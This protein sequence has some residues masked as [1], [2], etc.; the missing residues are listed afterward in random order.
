MPKKTKKPKGF[1]NWFTRQFNKSKLNLRMKL[2][3]LFVV[4][5]VLPL[6]I[7]AVI[8]WGQMSS[9]GSLL[10]EIAV[11]DSTVALNNSA[12]E[13]IE[14]MTTDTAADVAEFLY[15]R[16]DDIRYVASIVSALYSESG[17]SD[18]ENALATFVQN[19]FGGVTV[20]GEYILSEE[21]NKWVPTAVQDMSHTVGES[22]N[23]QN[24]DRLNGSGFHPVAASPLSSVEAP[25]YDEVTFIGL[26]GQEIVRISTTQMENSRKNA[27]ADWFTTGAL[28]DVSKRENTFCKAEVYWDAL[29]L[30]TNEAGAD[31]YVS[32][33]IGAYTPSNYIGTYTPENVDSASETRGYDIEY[34]PE[35]Q[36][37]AGE[38]N[39]NGVR[40]EG[41]VR[42]A[43]PVYVDGQKVGYVTLALDHDHI[44]EFVDHQTPMSE[45]YTELPSAAAGNY[46]FIWDYQCRSICHPRHNSIVGYDPETGLEAI[47]WISE[48]IYRNLL[49]KC[50]VTDA[51]YDAY[52]A[53]ERYALLYENWAALINSSIDGQ[54][55]YDLIIGQATFENQARTGATVPEGQP[56]PDH[57]VAA[58]L[59]KLG[60]V[61]L[62]GRYLNNAPQCTGWLDLTERGGSGSLYILWSGIYKPNTAAAIPYYTGQYAPSEAN[63][64]SRVGF[65]FV[66]IGAGIED[67]TAPAD[68]TEQRLNEASGENMR[69][70]TLRLVA[71]TVGL[72]TVVVLIALWTASF[73]TGNIRFV[74]AGIGRFRRGERHFRFDTEKKDEFGQ[75]ED[76]FDEMANSVVNSVN[77][78]LVITDLDYKI[79]YMNQYALDFDHVTLEEVIGKSYRDYGM[80]PAGSE[81]DPIH[82]LLEGTEA[83]VYPYNSEGGTVYLRGSAHYLTDEKGEKTGFIIITNDVSELSLKQI[84]LEQAVE[85]ANIA[86]KHKGEFLARMSH[87]IRTPMNAI[88]GLGDIMQRDLSI[89]EEEEA[90]LQLKANARQIDQ[91][92]RHLLNLINDILDISKIEAGKIEMIEEPVDMAALT[93]LVVGL[94]RPRCDEKQ[95]NFYT[96]SDPQFPTAYRSDSLRLRQVLINLLGNAVKFTPEK[97]AVTLTVKLIERVNGRAK[98]HF[99]VR[100]TGIGIA[101]DA[102]EGIFQPFEQGSA[103][104]TRKHGGTGL[105]LSISR[106]IIQLMGGD[107]RV[108]SQLG[109]GSEFYFDLWLDETEALVETDGEKKDYTDQFKGKRILLVDD[110]ELNRMIVKAMLE[111]TGAEIDEAGDGDLAVEMFNGSPVGYYDLIF[112]DVLMPNV[113]GYSATGRIRALQRPDAAAVPIIALTA[114]AFKDDIDKAHE[115][116]MNAHLAK[117]IEYEILME[118]LLN[119]L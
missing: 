102:L 15:R 17:T 5:K 35:A 79:T 111:G 107:I 41:I 44:M 40:F 33:V 10:T 99:S 82:A 74:I 110:V 29:P 28:R 69:D 109:E 2:I 20:T 36:S 59:T 117:P 66:A 62:D 88:I 42:W 75:L 76:S 104:I 12:V 115:S 114:N 94:V 97:G 53:E 58:D 57:T 105:G 101:E 14:R 77:G 61:G 95:L 116:G 84:A 51:T 23:T 54:P 31:I 86:N 92:S 78:P 96:K 52:T 38:E 65:G 60:M 108:N 89:L 81:Y 18:V 19:Q 98:I 49:E 55:V 24:E 87:E 106:R 70:T 83:K 8:A 119:W 100:D 3:L 72:V 25:L 46:A 118:V 80:Y 27:Y 4:I 32:D 67:F 91:S 6:I 16:D 56:D 85:A 103:N 34:A 93:S 22:S 113:D 39:P 43:S 26:D 73:L 13:S 112:M 90:I 37:Y 45:R 48:T 9:L 1:N 47:P 11:E 7:I 71:A 68:A 21:E 63:N 50:G 64:Y 30:L